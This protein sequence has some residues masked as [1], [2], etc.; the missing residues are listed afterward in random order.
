MKKISVV[1]PVYYN[2]GSLALLFEKLKMVEVEL[3]KKTI[4]LELVFVDDG[5]GDNSFAEMKKIKEQRPA[6]KLVKLTK[7]F[8]AV[9]AVKQGINYITGDAYLFLAADLQDPPEAIL[10]MTDH[11]LAGSKFVIMVR[12]GRDDPFISKL[13]ARAYYKLVRLMIDKNYPATGFDLALMDK[14]FL[15]HTRNSSK[16]AYTPFFAYSLGFKPT[17]LFYERQKR[18]HGTSRWTFSKKIKIFLDSLLGFSFV[19]IR[20]ISLIGVTISLL[21]F[22]YGSTM[23]VQALLGKTI[24]P[25]FA[26]LATL[27]AFFSGMIIIML[28]IIGEYIWRILDEVNKRPESVVDEVH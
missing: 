13:F 10:E 18:V 26:T 1:V 28:G 8:G 23:I 3:A 2:E 14:E 4:E 27:I 17:I 24:I 6:T 7:N 5:S 21:S 25:G 20:L 12:Q 9:H 16:N 15:P 22:A 11:W 19:P